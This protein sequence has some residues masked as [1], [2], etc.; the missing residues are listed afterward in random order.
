VDVATN[1]KSCPA[2]CGIIVEVDDRRVISVRGDRSHPVSRGYTCA[3]G[4]ALPW[5]HHRPDRLDRPVLDGAPVDWSRC[6]DDLAGRLQRIMAEHGGDRIGVYGGGQDSLGSFATDRFMKAIGSQQIYSGVTVDVAPAWRAAEM[7][8]GSAVELT[9]RWVP[10]DEASRLVVF[11][12]CNP[13]VSHGYFTIL[14]DPVRRIRA[15]QRRGGQVFVVDPRRTETATLADRHLAVRPG[16]DGTLLAWLVRE[17]LASDRWPPTDDV[18]AGDRDALRDALSPFTRERVAEVLGVSPAELTGLF[19]A[20]ASA[21]RLSVVAGTGV[22]FSPRALVTEWL[23]WALLILTDSMDRPGGMWFDPGW[24]APLTDR[25]EWDH[26]PIGGRLDPG[27]ASRPELSRLIGQ[28]PAAALVDEI[29]AGH[30]RALFVWFGSPLTSLPNPARTQAAFATLDALTVM[31]VI[32]TPLSAMATHVLPTAGALERIDISGF[33][34]RTMLGPRVVPV[35][36]DRRPVWWV[37]GQLA[38]RMGLDLYEGRDPDTIDEM[39]LLGEAAPGSPERFAALT[40]AGSHGIADPL[41]H[42]WV[43]E[44]ALPDGR[45]RL[46]LPVLLPRLPGLLEQPEP[47]RPLVAVSRRE[48]RRNNASQ[49]TPG[50]HDEAWADL[51]V[52]PADAEAYGIADADLVELE[53]DNGRISGLRVRFD[54]RI[55]RG[56]VCLP[57]GWHETNACNLT[58]TVRDLD[59]LTGQPVMSALDVTIRRL[60]AAR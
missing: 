54:A 39:S 24:L 26:A 17:V 19:E 50:S 49:Y 43:R 40:R 47:K 46:V 13:I 38:R 16:T 57:H 29:E 25:T 34:G 30:I 44:H 55:R 48:L 53:S 59:P 6:L 41:W 42:G 28:N 2:G 27:P 10:E 4:R 22:T 35:G 33:T 51:L 11:V 1:C 9:P 5:F 7:I 3:K 12:G 58:S 56:V 8:S 31:D 21:G 32:E 15:F 52:H 37:L 23:R 14:P 36:A 45:W 60:A 20:V 18:L